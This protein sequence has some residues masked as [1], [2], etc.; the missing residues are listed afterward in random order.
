MSIFSFS[1][2]VMYQFGEL[3]GI[4]IKFEI[5]VRKQIWNFRQ[6]NF[7]VWE[8]VNTRQKQL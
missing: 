3:S 1:H 6:L 5:V 7:V 4:F 8:S 2:S